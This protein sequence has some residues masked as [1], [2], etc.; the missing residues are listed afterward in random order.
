M[1]KNSIRLIQLNQPA[2]DGK[3]YQFGARVHI[4]FVHDPLPVAGN[5]LGAEGQLLPDLLVVQPMRHQ[6][7]HLALSLAKHI[8][9]NNMRLL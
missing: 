1:S 6:F 4:E 5:R 7:K 8:Q 2:A 3:F 9:R